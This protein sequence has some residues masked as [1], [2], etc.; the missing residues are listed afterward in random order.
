MAAAPVAGQGLGGANVSGE[1]FVNSEAERYLRLLQ[2][3]GHVP[4]YPW[5]VRTFS[6][7]EV[8]LLVPTD[9]AHP[10]AAR[11]DYTRGQPSLRPLRVR[12]GTLYNTALP[13]GENEGAVWA[14]RGATGFVQAGFAGRVGPLSLTVAPIAFAAQNRTF[15]LL[16]NGRPEEDRYADPNRPRNIDLPQRF[17]E[18]ALVRMDP[19]QSTLRLDVLGIG[20]GLSTAN[21]HW[22]PAVD[23]PLILGNNAAGF[24][25]L[26]A[27]TSR[28]IRVGIGRV[29]GRLVWGDLTQS[30]YATTHPDSTRRFLSGVAATFMPGGVQGLEVGATRLFHI[31]WPEGGPRLSH[32]VKPIEPPLKRSLAP[33]DPA[34]GDGSGAD[35]Q[36]LSVFFRWV[37]PRSGFEVYGEYAREDHSWDFR[38]L[39]LQPDHTGAYMIGARKVWDSG[40]RMTAVRGEILNAQRSH[41]ALARPQTFFYTHSRAR[42]G[43]T[44]RGEVLG[45]PAVY[46]GAGASLVVD[47]YSPEGRL[48]FGW[49]RTLLQEHRPA[50][51]R[52]E[53]YRVRHALSAEALRFAGPLELVLRVSPSLELN[54]TPGDDAFNLHGRFTVALPLP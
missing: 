26:F 1:V 10:W 28:P 54:R 35:N 30:P 44:Q 42:Q 3:S 33:S 43:H 53:A 46:G 13:Y 48:T 17:G 37:L 50:S 4:L 39:L 16:P 40:S 25:H 21:Q 18:G 22:G 52:A 2:I 7:R 19:G 6:A 20:V 34:E 27:G 9:T 36:L 45:S 31:P 29:H 8:D 14:G 23:A 5:T 51:S 32:F 38:D 15:E 24:P 11:Y 47:R 12:A 49:S 41:L